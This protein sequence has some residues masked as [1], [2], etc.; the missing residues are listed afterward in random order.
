MSW[1]GPQAVHLF[2]G[3]F[4][5]SLSPGTMQTQGPLCQAFHSY[6]LGLPGVKGP[7]PRVEMAQGSGPS[8]CI[9]KA[10]SFTAGHR[11]DWL[12]HPAVLPWGDSFRVGKGPRLARVRPRA[13]WLQMLAAAT[14]N[15]CHTESPPQPGGSLEKRGGSRGR[16][17]KFGVFH[18]SRIESERKWQPTPVFL[19]G[20]SQ[21]WGSL[22]GFRLQGHTESDTTGV[23]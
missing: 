23:T 4:I 12:L 2:P 9:I 5:F 10:R 16:G 15:P 1:A 18:C 11:A 6:S 13:M 3:L 8:H 22:V 20:E 7:V 14:N 21:G 17:V 19:P